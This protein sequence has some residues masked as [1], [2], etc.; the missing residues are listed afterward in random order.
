MTCI[1]A[2]KNNENNK[3][4]IWMVGDTKISNG[5]NTITNEGSKILDIDL[6][7]KDISSVNQIT[8]YK[9][10][11]G[12]AFAGS[13]L[14]AYNVLNASKYFLGN[15]G[16]LKSKEQLPCLQS[17]AE[18]VA[19]ILIFYT[20]SI[21]SQSEIF[22]TGKCPVKNELELYKIKL[23]KDS[24]E[25]FNAVTNRLEMNKTSFHF[26]GDKQSEMK[27]EVIKMSGYL[28]KKNSEKHTR[29]RAPLY[30]LQ[31]VIKDKKF[32]SIGGNLQ[33]G[34]LYQMPLGTFSLISIYT[35]NLKREPTYYHNNIDLVGEIGNEIGVCKLGISALYIEPIN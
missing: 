32:N 6:K 27:T 21:Q 26:L 24:N 14:I 35:D 2:W 34:I 7:V 33:L 11:I 17:V 4:S 8:Y 25:I 19:K 31:K 18:K 20:K 3:P 16:G 22:I 23:E 1:I 29:E 9:S 13:S 12:F 5:S 30:A 15:I 28:S 10:T